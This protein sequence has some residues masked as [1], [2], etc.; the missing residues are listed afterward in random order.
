[1]SLFD[2]IIF[3]ADF[4]EEGREF[5]GCTELR[6]MFYSDIESGTDPKLALHKVA[7]E[8]LLFTKSFV[9]KQGGKLNSRS[10]EAIK[11][12]KESLD[13]DKK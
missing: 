1:M 5:S 9:E 12:F 7:L 4:I 10:E 3:V 2:E 13:L 6:I 8:E 11:Y